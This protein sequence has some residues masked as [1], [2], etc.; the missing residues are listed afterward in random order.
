MRPHQLN[1]LIHDYEAAS[2]ARAWEGTLS[3]TD[4]EADGF[5]NAFGASEQAVRARLAEQLEQV[6]AEARL[7]LKEL[8]R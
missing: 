3:F 2:G 4:D 6:I 7:T 5:I 1:I 8:R